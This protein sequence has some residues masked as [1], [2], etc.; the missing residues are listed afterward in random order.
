MQV[1]SEEHLKII[2]WFSWEK[3]KHIHGKN[4]WEK[5]KEVI[6]DFEVVYLSSE[7]IIDRIRGE[8]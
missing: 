2:K 6:T 7:K 3:W 4:Q 8:E 5:G 1:K